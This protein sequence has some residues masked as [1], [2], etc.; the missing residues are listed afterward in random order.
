MH[1]PLRIGIVVA[2]L[3]AAAGTA[4]AGTNSSARAGSW[5]MYGYDAAGTRNN[6]AERTLGVDTVSRLR[7]DWR[8]RSPG[9]PVYGTPAI[10]DGTLYAA[11]ISG[12]VFAVDAASGGLVWIAHPSVPAT[13]PVA[14][15]SSPLLTATDVVVG[16][17]NGIVWALDRATGAVDWASRPNNDVPAIWGSP[18]LATVRTQHGPR[19]LILVPIASNEE[20]YTTTQQQPCCRARGS[21]AALDPETGAVVWQTYTISAAWAKAGAAGASVWTSP[22][23]DAEL[24]R[25]FIATGNNFANRDDAPTTVTSDAIISI[26]AATGKMC[27]I[28]QRTHADTYVLAYK[29]GSEHPDFDFGDSPE[30]FRLSNGRAVVAA[31]QKSGVL[32][33]LDARTGESLDARQFLPSGELGGYFAD[34]AVTDG[35]VIGNGNDWPGYGGGETGGLAGLVATQF[36][37]QQPPKAGEVV[38]AAADASGRLRLKWRFIRPGKAILG[39]VAVAAGVAYVHVTQEGNLYALDAD[40][41]DPLA[42]VAVGPAVS[43]PAIADG[44]VYLG[45]GDMFN[46]AAA[47]PTTGGIVKLG[48]G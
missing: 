25:V 14:I 6:V 27:W 41:G 38:A 47:D 37:A 9:G 24:N 48:L 17:Q 34:S 28:N 10:D 44:A 32:H 12:N 45:Y 35:V 20:T 3:A 29:Q 4:S 15:S 16:D 42:R 26:D 11:D 23:Y 21:V 22:A 30:V 46:Y 13:F 31:G 5:A 18:T 8:F 2:C 19:Q 43:G 1:R 7:V 40:T 39:A 36:S 33:L